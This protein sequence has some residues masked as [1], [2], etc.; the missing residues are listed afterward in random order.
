[1]IKFQQRK[2]FRPWITEETL[3]MMKLWD[4]AKSEAS[5]LSQ[6]GIS[7]TIAWNNYKKLRNRVNN[8]D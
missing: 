6:A 1:M 5:A 4:N 3:H 2:N 7:D 8:R